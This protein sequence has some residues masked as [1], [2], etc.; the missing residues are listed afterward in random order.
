MVTEYKEEVFSYTDVEEVIRI[1]SSHKKEGNISCDIDALLDILNIA[2]HSYISYTCNL[3]RMTDDQFIKKHKSLNNRINSLMRMLCDEDIVNIKLRILEAH[4]G[5][6][7]LIFSHEGQYNDLLKLISD[8]FHN[9]ML[10]LARFQELLDFPGH[11]ECSSLLVK[12]SH[13][14]T[15]DNQLIISLDTTL[16]AFLERG[17]YAYSD[18]NEEY[19]GWKIECIK[20]LLT[21]I[22]VKR[23]NKQIF[24]ILNTSHKKN[25]SNSTQK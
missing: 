5:A 10:S 18:Y 24:F 14:K 21:R 19:Y 2:Y 1:Y 20:Y 8:E 6:E 4:V 15:P 23:T 7:A 16:S 9:L 12:P 13:P 22:N 11:S 25:K 17:G 3:N